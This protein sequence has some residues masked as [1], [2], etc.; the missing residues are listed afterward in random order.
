MKEL[1][2][3]E[4]MSLA[5]LLAEKDK[6]VR[7]NRI[8]YFKP[9]K[10]QS[11]FY[12]A[13]ATKSHRLLMAANRIGKT[14]GGAVEVT[15]HATGVYP[16]WWT[17]LRYKTPV[18]IIVG[19]INTERVRDI[20]QKE[21][22]GEP[23]DANAMGTGSIPAHLIIDKVRRAGIP[24]A[25]TSLIVRHVTGQNSKITFQS[26]ESGKEAW[27]GDNAH[28]VWLDEE[29]PEEIYTQA[30]RALVD[31]GG[32]LMMT[33]TPE[34]GVTEIVRK[35]TQEILEHQYLQNATWDDAP[36]I[37]AKVREEI[38]SALPAHERDM[39]SKGLPM[40]GS[41]LVY[42]IDEERI[43][44]GGIPIPE[45]WR[46]IS[47]I[48]FGFDHATAWVNMAYDPETDILY[49]T[50][51]VSINKT[52]IPEVASIIKKKGADRIP[53]AWPHDGLKHDSWS[54]R[55]VR[56]MYEGEGI[57]MLPDKFT[58]PPSPGMV[59][60]S[61]G[62]GI[63]AGIQ[64]ILSRMETGRFKVFDTCTDWFNEFRM[65]HRKNGKIVDRNDDIMAATRYAALSMRFAIILGMTYGAYIPDATEYADPEVGY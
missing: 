13:G 18:K 33:F 29:P 32:K 1:T 8:D 28:M 42:T 48:D 44:M 6:R 51:S 35:Y 20:L 31:L 10:Y 7:N 65:Y 40:V 39:R 62:I 57:R 59:E 64:F 11:D 41:G 55:T 27:M 17:G 58:N 5:K 45:H 38:L 61:G 3:E 36:H 43:K 19:G 63:E 47:G 14:F 4:R 12:E 16:K 2:S 23:S 60:G 25:I 24:N 21:L 46:R 26:Y 22:C 53:V 34:N 54:G 37:T 49:V 15:Y 52:V 56:D 30:L 50:E 9:Y